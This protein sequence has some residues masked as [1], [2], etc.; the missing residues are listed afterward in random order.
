MEGISKKN[1]TPMTWKTLYRNIWVLLVLSCGK[2]YKS[3]IPS[4]YYIDL[5]CKDSKLLEEKIDSISVVS[6]VID[7]SWKYVSAPLFTKAGDTFI[8]CDKQ[9]NHMFGYDLNGNKKFA[10]HIKGRGPGE[11]LSIENIY[12]YGDTVYLYDASMG[13]H[14][15]YDKE[16][17]FLSKWNVEVLDN[18]L[19]KIQNDE[20]YVGLYASRD[21]GDNY[22]NVYDNKGNI[23]D[24]YLSLPKHLRN[25]SI[26]IGLT[27]MAYIFKDTVRFMI[28][29]NY[30]I[31]SVSKEAFLSKYQFIPENPIP[32]D[33]FDNFD[34]NTS[35]MDLLSQV[36]K[37]GYDSM[38]QSVFEMERYLFFFYLS[39]GKYKNCLYDKENNSIYRNNM[40]DV[41]YEKNL[42][43]NMSCSDVWQYIFSSYLPLYSE[44]NH[45]YGRLSY[46]IYQMLE[47][48]RDKLDSRLTSL[49]HEIR[50]Y[51]DK[52]EFSQG[53][54]IIVRIDFS[55]S[56][57]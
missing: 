57:L 7:D 6:F 21:D 52:Y 17:K 47:D 32:S 31:F 25:R 9:T 22:V 51:I 35:S 13:N 53:D 14:L 37:G 27:P 4:E 33:F 2:E 5:N 41:Y 54:V 16:G 42:A 28:P 11:V 3:S 48:C 40:P 34:E 50:E 38:F 36:M 44:G 20:I 24:K 46:N 15:L 29:F 8:L 12:S 55:N 45:L 39:N 18:H 26:N 56:V 43:M 49:M 30:N 23:I 19:F 10:K 1:C